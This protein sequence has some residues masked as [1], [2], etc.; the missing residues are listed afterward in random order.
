[1]SHPN[2]TLSPVQEVTGL[3]QGIALLIQQSAQTN[4]HLQ[5]LTQEI[6]V[7]NRQLFSQAPAAPIAPAAPVAATTPQPANP[8]AVQSGRPEI[9]TSRC[10]E[11]GI[12]KTRSLSKWKLNFYVEGYTR[13]ACAYGRNGYQNLVQLVRG[14]FPEISGDHFSNELFAQRNQEWQKDGR[15]S[16]YEETFIAPH[17][18]LVDWYEKPGNDGRTYVYVD[19]VYPVS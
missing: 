3:E 12:S 16:N 2:G 11:L 4:R 18:F 5:Q 15:E 14:V 1:M 17:H 8:P 10:I 7:M 13:P 19:R 9:F 6:S